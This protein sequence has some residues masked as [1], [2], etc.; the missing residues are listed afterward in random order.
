MNKQE[1]IQKLQDIESQDFEVK[2]ARTEIPKNVWETVSAFSSTSGWLSYYAKKPVVEG[3]F[4]YYKITF[5]LER[6]K[7][8][9]AEKMSQKSTRKIPE[10]YQK[11][12]EIISKNPFI[13]RK[14]LALKLGETEETIQSRLRKLVKEQ[15]LLRIG[16][17]KGGHWEVK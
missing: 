3:D 4:D 11:I 7:C 2:E 9:R 10:K 12:I 14:E 13:S 16:P 17:D 6:K 8:W 15:T 5:Y 1:L